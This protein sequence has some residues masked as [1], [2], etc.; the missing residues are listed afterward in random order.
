MPVIYSVLAR[1]VKNG[2]ACCL[3]GVHLGLGK[4]QFQSFRVVL[5]QL[6]SNIRSRAY[7][8][9]PSSPRR[10]VQSRTPVRARSCLTCC[11]QRSTDIVGWTVTASEVL[12]S[13]NLSLCFIQTDAQACVHTSVPAC[14]SVT[15][16]PAFLFF[17]ISFSYILNRNDITSSS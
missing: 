8:V 16:Y 14:Q 6:R 1:F 13:K 5:F 15:L 7:D 17:I 3:E 4:E 9:N 2:Y 11:L 12:L 10:P